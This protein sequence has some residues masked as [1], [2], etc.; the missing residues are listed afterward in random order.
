[1]FYISNTYGKALE[2]R[3]RTDVLEIKIIEDVMDRF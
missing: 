1:M 3:H 2:C